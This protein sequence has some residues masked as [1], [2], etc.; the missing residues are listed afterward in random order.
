MYRPLLVTGLI[1]MAYSLSLYRFRSLKAR[2]LIYSTLHC[3]SLL[4][5][6]TGLKNESSA[7]GK[8]LQL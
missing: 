6:I 5:F 2:Y 8:C 4:S 1:K 3:F 7:F